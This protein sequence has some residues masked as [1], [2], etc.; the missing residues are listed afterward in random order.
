VRPNTGEYA[1]GYSKMDPWKS[2]VIAEPI[3]I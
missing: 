2:R 3:F 1:N